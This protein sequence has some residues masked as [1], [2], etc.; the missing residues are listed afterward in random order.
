MYA[1]P[2]TRLEINENLVTKISNGG[3]YQIDI[4]SGPI[5]I[6]TY[7]A[8]DPGKFTIKL[9]VF[10]KALQEHG[11]N[12]HIM[13]PGEEQAKLKHQSEDKT[14]KGKGTGTWYCPMHCEGENC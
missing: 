11:G 6:S 3:G 5:T 1:I 10:E 7:G 13:L 14:P 2:D 4:P 8:M 12:Y 9:D